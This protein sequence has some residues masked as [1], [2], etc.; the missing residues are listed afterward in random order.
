MKYPRIRELLADAAYW[1]L[2]GDDDQNPIH[3][4][5]WVVKGIDAR[6]Q[7]PG[8]RRLEAVVEVPV[9]RAEGTV[10]QKPGYDPLTGIFFLPGCEYPEIPDKLTRNDAIS[11]RDVLLEVVEDFPFADDSHRAAWSAGV[12][13]PLARYAFSGPAPLFLNDANVRGCGKSLLTAFLASRPWRPPC[14]CTPS[15]TR[16]EITS[17]WVP[18]PRVEWFTFAWNRPRKIPKA[19]RGFT[20][21]ICFS[22]RSKIAHG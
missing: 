4:P 20:M 14:L 17:F 12:L 5:E 10:L 19:G 18:I 13:T 22:G 7:W 15:G 16:P 2:A 1:Y 6:G 9:L 21:P 11:A 3:P 8:I